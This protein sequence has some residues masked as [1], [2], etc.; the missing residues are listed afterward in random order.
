[1]NRTLTRR[2]ATVAVAASA[3]LLGAC[4]IF[5]SNDGP[6]PAVLEAGIG[7]GSAKVVWSS[8]I[9]SL[10]FPLAIAAR[11][12]AFVVAGTD[13]VVQ[14]LASAD[15]H[16]LWRADAGRKLTAGVGSDGRF[17]AVV[18]RDNELV[19]FD[20]GKQRWKT[21]LPTPAVTAPFVAGE[22]V[23]VLTLDR[24]VFAYDA[25][26]GR[27]LFDVSR[28]G[29]SLTLAKAG[30]LGAWQDTL[31]VGQGSRM[32]GLDPLRG[33]LRWEAAVANPRGTNEVERLA[34]L[35]GP[36]ERNDRSGNILCARAYQS[37]V[38]CVDAERGAPLWL[39]NSS[40]TDGI[41]ADAEQVYGT[42]DSSRLFAWKIK[43]G[44]TAWMAEQ[45]RHR[46]LGVPIAV[47]KFVLVGDFEGYVH[48]V[49]RLTGKTVARVPTDGAPITVAPVELDGVVLFATSKGGL[50]AIKPE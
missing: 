38:G 22:R 27:K 19:V 46:E 26:D 10:D 24:E 43:N 34:D 4:S 48:F 9:D 5:K 45:F 42:D 23:F 29:D 49:D 40:G 11:D 3:L 47:G 31:V 13:G 12:H 14:A 41:G 2:F 17:A 21:T 7:A 35:V 25:L 18:T 36:L 30:V 15:G 44:D 37:A 20:A 50:F 6:Q 8:R 32:T 1:M 33:S 16:A 28:P 39:R